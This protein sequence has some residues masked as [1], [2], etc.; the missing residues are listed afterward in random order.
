MYLVRIVRQVSN[1]CVWA[2]GVMYLV[3]EAV[4][5]GAWLASLCVAR[6]P[7]EGGA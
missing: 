5:A 1:R 7:G 6:E 4:A 3:R 2:P